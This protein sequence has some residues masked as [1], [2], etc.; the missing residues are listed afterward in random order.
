MVKGKANTRTPFKGKN[1]MTD[2]MI[3]QTR[4]NDNLF[5]EISYGAGIF[6]QYLVGLTL[7]DKT[8]K[9]LKESQCFTIDSLDD[10]Q[11]VKAAIDKAAE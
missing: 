4:I 8:G 11:N 3:S 5:M 6:S 1:F 2:Y 7:Q 9:T 10:V